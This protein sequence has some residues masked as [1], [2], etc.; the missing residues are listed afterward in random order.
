VTEDRVQWHR[1]WAEMQRWLEEFELKHIEMRRCIE[2]YQ[3]MSLTWTT[4]ATKSTLPGPAAFARR[5]AEI[6]NRLHSDALSLFMNK[7]EPCFVNTPQ[8][9]LVKAILNFREQE[10]GWLTQLAGSNHPAVM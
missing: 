2:S 1:A 5:Q 4:L 7:G 3:T 10:L 9:G 6:Y 8:F